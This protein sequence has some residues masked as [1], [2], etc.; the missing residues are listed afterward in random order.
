MRLDDL[1]G[2]L[3]NT[4]GLAESIEWKGDGESH[5]WD[6]ISLFARN[7]RDVLAGY[8][9]GG[10]ERPGARWQNFLLKSSQRDRAVRICL[11][12]VLAPLPFLFVPLYLHQTEQQ[13]PRG[14]IHAPSS[15]AALEERLGF[16]QGLRDRFSPSDVAIALERPA[17]EATVREVAPIDPPKPTFIERAPEYNVPDPTTPKVALDEREW[18]LPF[19]SHAYEPTD[20]AE[21]PDASFRTEIAMSALMDP[22]TTVAENDA[23]TTRAAPRAKA[24]LVKRKKRAAK[25]RRATPPNQ[26]TA[27]ASQAPTIIA[28]PQPNLPPPPILFFLGAP[29]PQAQP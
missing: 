8:F 18:R 6:R 7:L 16:A 5:R 15:E 27:A 24:G 21:T 3:V 12:A 29:P 26:M 17:P 20:L 19:D 14:D 4:P 25:Y 11:I 28:Q 9:V 13:T 1:P 10:K 22:V 2:F 23:A